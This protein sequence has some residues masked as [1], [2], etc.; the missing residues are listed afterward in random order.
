MITFHAM[1]DSPHREGSFCGYTLLN[2]AGLYSDVLATDVPQVTV[3]GVDL[4]FR[5]WRHRILMIVPQFQ[6]EQQTVN[7]H[8]RELTPK[9]VVRVR[10]SVAPPA[11]IYGFAAPAGR[12]ERGL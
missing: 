7:V 11:P 6:R 2:L 1:P 8:C 4:T 10:G 5:P 9:A 12:Y 3:N